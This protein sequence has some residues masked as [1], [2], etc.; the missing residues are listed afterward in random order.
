MSLKDR[1]K[2]LSALRAKGSFRGSN[3]ELACSFEPEK[4]SISRIKDPS[5][6]KKQFLER[7]NTFERVR[8]R[9]E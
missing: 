7:G 2:F 4:P 3:W 5:L 9:R 8:E 1:P 6:G